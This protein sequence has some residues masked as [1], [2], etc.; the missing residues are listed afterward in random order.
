M[1]DLPGFF[2]FT[3]I[4]DLL[5]V[6]WD[7]HYIDVCIPILHVANLSRYR[8]AFPPDHDPSGLS[9]VGTFA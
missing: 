4:E 8:M 5:S 6:Y 2:L 9:S 3:I 7:G 1:D